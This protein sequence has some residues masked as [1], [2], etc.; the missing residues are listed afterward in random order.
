MKYPVLRALSRYSF[1]TEQSK[2]QMKYCGAHV[3]PIGL[4][5]IYDETL[6]RLT[7]PDHYSNRLPISNLMW[8]YIFKTQNHEGSTDADLIRGRTKRM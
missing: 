2:A 5:L 8:H 7:G 3:S 6:Q 4:R 1:P